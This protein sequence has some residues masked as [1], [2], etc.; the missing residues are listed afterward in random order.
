MK[1]AI[2]I[3]AKS[4]IGKGLAKLLT[5]NNYKIGLT[6]RRFELLNE[7]K[8]ENPNFYIKPFDINDT[9]VVGQKLMNL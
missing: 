4:G 9:N 8:I 5:E 6:G 7:L 2:I 3:G 1:R